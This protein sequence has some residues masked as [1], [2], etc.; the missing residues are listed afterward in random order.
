MTARGGAIWMVLALISAVAAFTLKY[1]VRDL[2]EQLASLEHQVSESRETSHVLRAEWSYL[3]RPE[4]LAELAERHLDL[5]P[6][7]VD[8]MGQLIQVPLREL[9]LEDEILPDL[10]EGTLITYQVA[11]P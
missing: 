4:R 2:E 11:Q 8:Q 6:M 9:P 1:E 3:S 7:G 10:G 5:A